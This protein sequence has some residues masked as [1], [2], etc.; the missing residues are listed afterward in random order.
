MENHRIDYQGQLDAFKSLNRPRKR[1][2][3]FTLWISLS[4]RCSFVACAHCANEFINHQW[5]LTSFTLIMGALLDAQANCKQCRMMDAQWLDSISSILFH[6]NAIH[7]LCCQLPETVDC[8]LA[9]HFQ[10]TLYWIY[11]FWWCKHQSAFLNE[12]FYL[13]LYSLSIRSTWTFVWIW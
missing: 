11:P 4:G 9:K 12:L 2:N 5:N 10:W 8:L 1:N 7:I 3:Q 6:A 13:H